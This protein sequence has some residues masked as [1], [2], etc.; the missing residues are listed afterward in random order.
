MAVAKLV[1][2]EC[3][4]QLQPAD[5]YCSHCGVRIEGPALLDA[6]EI[7]GADAKGDGHASMCKVCG[8]INDPRAEYCVSCGGTL[9]RALT[10]QK[11]G[12]LENFERRP[13]SVQRSQ[14]PKTRSSKG[15]D[16]SRPGRGLQ[17]ERWQVVA[18]VLIAGLLGYFLYSEVTR[19]TASGTA[20]HVHDNANPAALQEIER[21]TRDVNANPSDA[22]SL[23]KLAN[24]LHDNAHDDAGLWSRGV[25][26]Y[27]KY[28]QLHPDDPDARVDLGICYFELSRLDRTGA[29]R[30]Y[31]LAVGE[32]ENVIKQNP[33]HQSAAFNLG[34]INLNAGNTEESNK[35]FKKAVDINSTNDL[36]QRAKRL[37]EQHTFNNNPTN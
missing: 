13:Q 33:N 4:G 29:G 22:A 19:P 31:G 17:L 7:A 14:G 5:V 37:L 25:D 3:G 21:L 26:A 8:A 16:S 15:R 34:I 30:Y 9:S 36:G 12:R 10:Q 11:Q 20:P 27:K 24:L 32:M 18:G 23:L 2:G 35:W 28:L 6:R 1:C